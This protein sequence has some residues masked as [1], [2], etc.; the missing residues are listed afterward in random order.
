MH[1]RCC[2]IFKHFLQ[3]NNK[4]SECLRAVYHKSNLLGLDVCA[5]L[6]RLRSNSLPVLNNTCFTLIRSSG[7]LSADICYMNLIWYK[8]LI[9]FNLV[10]VSVDQWNGRE[11]IWLEELSGW[12]VSGVCERRENAC[13]SEYRL[14]LFPNVG[15]R[16]ML[17]LLKVL[18]VIYSGI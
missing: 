4:E 16:G 11:E 1:F 15:S 13:T 9:H 18:C 6:F 2:L 7:F 10:W 12:N 5:G 3:Q 17:E 14:M 8:L